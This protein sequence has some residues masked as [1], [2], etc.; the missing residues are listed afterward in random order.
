MNVLDRHAGEVL[1]PRFIGYP[2]YRDFF[3]VTR[4]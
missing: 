2:D 4:R 1:A 3:Y